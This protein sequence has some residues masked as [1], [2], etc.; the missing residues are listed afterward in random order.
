MEFETRYTRSS[1]DVHIAYQVVGDAPRD[2][3]IAPGWIFHLE[4][5]WE[6]PSFE[7]FM[8]RLTRSFRVVMFDKRGTGLSDRGLG[9]SS[10]EDRM[11]DLRAVMDA[12]EAE[13]AAVMGWS[14][15]GNIAAMFAAMFPE[16][17][18]ALI[19]YGAAARYRWAPDYPF[20]MSEQSISAAREMLQSQWGTGLMALIAAPTRAQDEALRRWFGRLE[21]MSVSP[22]QALEMID[23]NLE[24]DT[25]DVLG[26]VQVPTL[27][28]HNERDALVSVEASRYL[29]EKIPGAKLVELPGDD[30]LFWFSNSDDVV[31]EIE[32]FLLGARTDHTSERVFIHRRVHGHR[33]IHRACLGARRRALA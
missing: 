23:V 27:I 19:L 10:M 17:V 13:R 31:G 22:G 32:D 26:H 14:E 15:G 20:G 9:A 29:A 2:L 30:H 24:I 7:A 12:A 25:T 28:L 5:I 33:Q 16:R 21:R 6:Q 4:V 8:R 3:V 18:E 11:D 1:G